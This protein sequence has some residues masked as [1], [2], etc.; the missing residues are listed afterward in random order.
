MD[1]IT[2]TE[3]AGWLEETIGC[4]MEH[5]PEKIGLCAMLPDGCFLTSYFGECYPADKALMA[6]TISS[7]ATMDTIKA[8]AR[9]ILDAAEEQEG[10]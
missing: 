1:D 4:I 6:Y 10:E 9:D 3:Y 8:N 2:K 5:K 7:D